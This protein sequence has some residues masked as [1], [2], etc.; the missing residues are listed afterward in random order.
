MSY[1]SV[2]LGFQTRRFS[3]LGVKKDFEY[4]PKKLIINND[5]SSYANCRRDYNRLKQVMM[6]AIYKRIKSQNSNRYKKIQ[7][8]WENFE[9]P[10]LKKELVFCFSTSKDFEAFLKIL[11]SSIDSRLALSFTDSREII[12]V[13]N[14]LKVALGLDPLKPDTNYKFLSIAESLVLPINEPTERLKS[15]PGLASASPVL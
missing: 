10:E 2:S 12:K 11:S 14:N 5:F 15:L 1:L 4:R 6:A 3:S 9:T 13:G 7:L 8:I